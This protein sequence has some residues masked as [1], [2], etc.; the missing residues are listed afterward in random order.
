MEFLVFILKVILALSL[1]GLIGIDREKSKKGYPAGIRTLAFISLLGFLTS[2]VSA[3]LNNY[4]FLAIVTLLIFTLIIVGYGVSFNTEKSFGFTSTMAIFLTFII[5]VLSYYDKYYYF[6]VSLS[7]IVTLLLTQKLFIHSIVSKIKNNELFDALKFSI[8]AFIILPL[9]P[10]KNID[11]FNI[12]NPYS[13][14]LLIV[15]ILSINYV[16][17]IFSRIIGKTKG[18]YVSGFL[19]GIISSTAVTSSLSAM[20]RKDE[21]LN[22]SCAIGITLANAASSIMVLIES[23]VVNFEFGKTL[24]V[25]LI[26]YSLIGLAISL[27]MIKN[28]NKHKISS[29][30]IVT[31]SPF[32]FGSA[33][34]FTLIVA[35][36]LFVSKIALMLFGDSGVY[37]A[38]FF[39]GL[40]STSS[41]IITI[42][43]L[44]NESIIFRVA[45]ISVA[46]SVLANNLFKLFLVKQNGSVKLF[47][48]L[49]LNYV[50]MN[51]PLVIWIIALFV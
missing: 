50:L 4:Y 31:E 15:L 28:L 34:K 46:I 19:G 37:L 3:D 49:L 25:P 45:W 8:V 12:F 16:G 22:E 6:A 14:W 42:S 17:Y 1:G 29:T 47:K 23:L 44:V 35:F 20:S 36:T 24:T 27:L 40:A 30:E 2:F 38:S 21:N 7:I 33:L 32:S 18:I 9:L 11:P 41:V 5:G 26:G 39:S 43:T 13:L 51:A 48:K 10:N